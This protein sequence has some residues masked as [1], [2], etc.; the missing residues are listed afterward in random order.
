MCSTPTVSGRRACESGACEEV[1]VSARAAEGKLLYP[2]YFRRKHG[3]Y[4]RPDD[5]FYGI[6]DFSRLTFRI[7]GS[8]LKKYYIP[9]LWDSDQALTDGMQTVVLSNGE[10]Q[11]QAIVVVFPEHPELSIVSGNISSFVK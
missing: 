1:V 10:D 7:L 11:A 8:S 2:R 5:I 9:I 6:Q 3:F 4:E